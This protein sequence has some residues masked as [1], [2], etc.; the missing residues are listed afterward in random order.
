MGTWCNGSTPRSHR[1]NEGSIPSVS[2][3]LYF[4]FFISGACK[5]CVLQVLLRRE[6]FC[7]CLILW[8]LG[9]FLYKSSDESCDTESEED[10]RYDEVAIEAV[11]VEV[12]CV[13]DVEAEEA[14][15]D[16]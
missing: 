8:R 13:D 5:F 15:C 4:A 3:F 9:F 6:H 1:G 7:V 12:L 16:D 11:V 10:K 2:I 14:C